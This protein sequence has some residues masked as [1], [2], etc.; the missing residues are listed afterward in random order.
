M[1]FN[2]C[3]QHFWAEFGIQESHSAFSGHQI[4]VGNLCFMK[5]KDSC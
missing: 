1:A 3:R 2:F 4:F 5:E